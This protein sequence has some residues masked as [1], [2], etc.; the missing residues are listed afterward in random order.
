MQ[1][2]K[3]TLSTDHTTKIS[4]KE[5]G[6]NF[7]WM[8]R[9]LND[10]FILTI[11]KVFWTAT[12]KNLFFAKN[13]IT[14]RLNLPSEKLESFKPA[15]LAVIKVF[16]F[17]EDRIIHWIVG[18]LRSLAHGLANY[19]IKQHKTAGKKS[20]KDD[21][22]KEETTKVGFLPYVVSKYDSLYM[23]YPFTKLSRIFTQKT[24]LK[25]KWNKAP[26]RAKNGKVV[27]GIQILRYAFWCQR[28]SHLWLF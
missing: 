17:G 7:S 21:K 23:S 5:H 26:R 1:Q 18:E 13:V 10:H 24:E 27:N 28:Y 8:H 16:L 22:K 20:K 19:I 6:H 12:S 4:Y 11:V 14:L 9:P 3:D 15:K 2:T 25:S